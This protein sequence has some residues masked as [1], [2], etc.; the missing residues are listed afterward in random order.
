[1]TILGPRYYKELT[2][3]VIISARV[4]KYHMKPWV[5]DHGPLILLCR[6]A[7]RKISQK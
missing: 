7:R 4:F 2:G 5:Y 1:M 3:P 6:P